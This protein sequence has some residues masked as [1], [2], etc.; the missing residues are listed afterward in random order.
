MNKVIYLG[1][2][3]AVGLVGCGG[4]GDDGVL[5]SASS[6]GNSQGST[7]QAEYPVDQALGT[8]FSTASTFTVSATDSSGNTY[9]LTHSMVP[10]AVKTNTS[11]SATAKSTTQQIVS[12]RVNGGAPLGNT[13]EYFYTYLHSRLRALTIMA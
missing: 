10:G 5:Q 4:G 1:L 6:G 8:F 2:L 13:V 12:L 9:S 7:A 11:I 3:V